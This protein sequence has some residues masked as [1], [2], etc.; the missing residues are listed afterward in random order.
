[1][2]D[3]FELNYYGLLGI[4]LAALYSAGISTLSTSYNALTTLF[5]EEII[6][7]INKKQK[8]SYS[9]ESKLVKRLR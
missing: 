5:I 8:I 9:Y 3:N 4:L 1:M 2:K 7:K 6:K